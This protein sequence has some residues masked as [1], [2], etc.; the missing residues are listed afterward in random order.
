MAFETAPG[1]AS[2]DSVELW[3]P[4]LRRGSFFPEF[5]ELR[6]TAEQALTAMI[7]EFRIKGLSTRL[8]GDLVKA[9]GVSGISKSQVSRLCAELD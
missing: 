9:M 7:Q 6:R 3:I 5:L 8:E 1:G 2:A 4:K